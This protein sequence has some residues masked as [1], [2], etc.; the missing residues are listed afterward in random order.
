MHSERMWAS[1]QRRIYG[2]CVDTL[3]HLLWVP[4]ATKNAVMADHSQ[5]HLLG[6]TY[7]RYLRTRRI[8][9]DGTYVVQGLGFGGGQAI[10]Q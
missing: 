8:D 1:P 5:G 3:Q 7:P 9:V 4:P 10:E 2:A 6:E